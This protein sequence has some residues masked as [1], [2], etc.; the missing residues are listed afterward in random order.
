MVT[1]HRR[2]ELLKG[3]EQLGVEHVLAKPVNA[4]L[5]VNT[6]MQLMGQ[7]PEQPLAVRA[8]HGVS[9]LEGALSA[10]AGAR[11]L[12]VEDN[13]INQ[14]VA[15]DML[16]GVG[17]TVDVAENGQIG[18]NQVHA[19]QLQSE[20]YDL[21][22]MDMQMPVMDGITAARLIRQSYPAQVLPIVAMTA[23]AMQADKERC[24]SA[25]MNGFVS[26]PIHPEDLWRALHTW[27]KGREGLGQTRA[28][29]DAAAADSSP[30]PQQ[31]EQLQ[32]L[33]ATGLLDVQRGLSLSNRNA[34]LYLS[35]LGKFVKSQE[36]ALEHLQ[37]ALRKGERSTAERLAHTLKGLAASMGA[38][39]LREGAAQLE[40]ALHADADAQQLGLLMQPVQAQLTALLSALRATPGILEQPTQAGL[41]LSPAQQAELQPVIRTLRQLLE[42][43]DSEAQAL[44]QAH[45]AGLH[46]VLQQAQLLEDAIGQFDFEEALRLLA[47]QT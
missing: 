14:M 12:L 23:N 35:M 3:A 47:P 36:H 15:C 45:A 38:E 6:M 25:G 20:P 33:Q 44:W 41:A 7:K 22:L 13:E 9:E 40:H 37:D 5:L 24:L 11:I 29:A 34:T 46:A 10:L 43:D 19:M 42:Q 31:T 1:A 26:K 4:S 2:Q 27:I 32:R 18:V 28:V 30:A 8:P 39:A 16:R 21:V 17:F